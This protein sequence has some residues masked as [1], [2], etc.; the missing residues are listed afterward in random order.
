MNRRTVVIAIVYLCLPFVLF[1]QYGGHH[2]GS[3]SGTNPTS[4][5]AP[6]DNSDVEGFKYAVA[7]QATDTQVALYKLLTKS[8]NA[9]RQQAQA[10]QQSTSDNPVSQATTLQKDLDE[11]QREARDFLNS[12]TDAQTAGLKKQGKK[13]SEANGAVA[14]EAK[15]LEEQLNRIPPDP[16]HLRS[17]AEGVEKALASFRSV[18]VKV[19]RAMGIGAS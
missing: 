18:Q 2:G 7:V 4:P 19:G 1:G 9:S 6:P 13:L 11:L 14:K 5:N 10:L 3:N 12:F 8:T 15:K 16:Q 17:I